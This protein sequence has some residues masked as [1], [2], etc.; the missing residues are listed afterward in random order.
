MPAF[1]V[2]L[3][4][5]MVVASVPMLV[6]GLVPRVRMLALPVGGQTFIHLPPTLTAGHVGD[7][8]VHQGSPPGMR[9]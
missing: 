4:V 3:F 1:L 6:R 5:V 7:P 2:V 9:G 8:K